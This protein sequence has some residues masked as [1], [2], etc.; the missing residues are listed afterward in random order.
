MNESVK[1]RGGLY[2][3]PPADFI[4]LDKP[5]EHSWLALVERYQPCCR[6]AYIDT[7]SF[8]D[9]CVRSFLE[10]RRRAY[11]EWDLDLHIP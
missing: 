5:L 8:R 11:H 6:P 4:P 10:A 7:R 3:R 1:S 2:R 9:V